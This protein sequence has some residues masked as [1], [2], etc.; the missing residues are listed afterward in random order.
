MEPISANTA[1]TWQTASEEVRRLAE[2]MA[3]EA[4]ASGS[5]LVELPLKLDDVPALMQMLLSTGQLSREHVAYQSM[6]R[7][8]Y[9]SVGMLDRLEDGAFE[10]PRSFCESLKADLLQMAG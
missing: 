10:N 5:P 8:L 9:G 2:E 1:G 4:A 7:L 6:R 3:A